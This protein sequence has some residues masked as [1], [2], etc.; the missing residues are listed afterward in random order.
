MRTCIRFLP[1]LSLCAAVSCVEPDLEI[2]ECDPVT[3]ENAEDCLRIN[4]LQT[5]GTHNSYHLA[6]TPVLMEAV[7][8]FRPGWSEDIQYTHRPLRDQLDL[9]GI[10]QLEI[11]VFAD[12]EGGLYS[13][14]AGALLV[15]DEA[16]LDRPEML[17]P[18]F[19]V[20]HS[21]DF[22]YRSS[23]LT[24]VGCLREIRDWSVAN[25]R[26]LPVLILVEIKDRPRENRDSWGTHPLTVPIPVDESLI[27][28]IDAEIRAVFPPEQVITPDEVRGDF[29]TLEKA[30]LTRGW[31][32]LAQSRG[33]VIFA[34]DNTGDHRDA[35]L[36]GS[37]DLSG[38]AMFVSSPPGEPTAAF[39]KMND[40]LEEG[41]SI[42]ERVAAGYLVRTRSDLP[43]QEARTGDTTRREA[44]L[45]S[46]AQFVSTDYPEPSPFDSG[47]VV[48][49]PGTEG[50]GRCNP[51]SAPIGC[52]NAFLSE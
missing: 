6:P 24:F 37:P 48:R 43:I 44:A 7:D 31:P 34:V 35:Y 16:F 28:E 19:K 41:A 27:L 10:R 17:E 39:I 50:P 8:A 38:R 22:D 33:R 13:R 23:C 12:P 32:T 21:Q 26:H 40:A 42:A 20:L 3:A 11:D 52:Q 2:A 45:S 14:P 9:L 15:G 51:V 4:H 49:L 36:S 29:G 25:P 46:G 18:G 47:Y 1:L 30:I 5:L